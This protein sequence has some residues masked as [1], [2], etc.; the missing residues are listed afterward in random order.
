MN[1]LLPPG[2]GH[3]TYLHAMRR[4]VVPA[5]ERF[6][7]ELVVIASGLARQRGRPLGAPDALQRLL[8]GDDPL[9]GGAAEGLCD[10]RLVTAYEGGYAE[11]TVPFCVAPGPARMV[12]ALLHSFIRLT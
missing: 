8:P 5:L 7:A 12:T 1:V 4:V 2:S 11:S 10:G 3:D 9:G 6:E